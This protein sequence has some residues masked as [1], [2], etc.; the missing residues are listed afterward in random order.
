VG[1][2]GSTIVTMGFSPTPALAEVREFKLVRST[3][4]RNTCP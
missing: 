4:T 1:L 3:E 2:A